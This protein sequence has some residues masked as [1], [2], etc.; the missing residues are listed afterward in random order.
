MAQNIYDTPEF[1]AAY[2]R[3]PRSVEGLAGAAEWPALRALLPDV[4]GLRIVDLGCGYGWFCRWARENGAAHVQG[5][6]VSEKMLARARAMTSDPAIVYARADLDHLTLP[7]A[8]FD[9]AFSSLT[10]HYLS[11]LPRLLAT[12]HRALVAGRH[13]VVSVEHPILTAPAEP[14]WLVDPAG[15]K[16]WPVDSYGNEGPRVTDWLAKGVVKQHRTLATYLNA[17]VGAG[18]AI[19][20]VEEWQ[21][22]DAQIVEHPEWREERD[23]PMFLLLSARR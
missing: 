4:R 10:L 14:G 19:A 6:D 3:L 2:S 15:R 22:S 8:A 5:F 9:L 7:A 17:L 18:F 1:F 23:R 20:H 21:P 12:V 16:R 11:D 13:L